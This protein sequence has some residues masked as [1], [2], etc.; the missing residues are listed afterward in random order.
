MQRD[1][2][3]AYTN[4]GQRNVTVITNFAISQTI[5]GGY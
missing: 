4:R 5:S 1:V 2:Q 3:K